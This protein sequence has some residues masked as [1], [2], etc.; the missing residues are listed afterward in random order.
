VNDFNYRI[1][2]ETHHRPWPL[3]NAPWCMTQT[4]HNLLFAHWPVDAGALRALV[5][6]VLQLD[7]YGGQAWIGV[8][9]FRMTNVAPRG[10]P[11]VPFVSA[12]PELNVRTYVTVGGKP[13]V[14]FF[15]LDAGSTVAVAAARML[16]GLPYFA[17][18]MRLDVSEGEVRYESEREPGSV[19]PAAFVGRYHP[20]GPVEPSLAG[21]LEHF[22]TER[23]CL[24]RVD[25]SLHTH[26][27][28]VHHEQWPLQVA[29]ATIERNT[30]AEAAGIRLPATAPLLHY[31][32]RMDMVAWAPYRVTQS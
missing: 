29:D 30:M 12:F 21:T 2:D 5:P 26:R 11:N 28:E 1:L 22:L 8:I 23:Y 27:L 20:T 10:I 15:S 19:G 32:H 3:P 9:P 7:V 16:L 6:Q 18:R 14:Y 24:Y 17:A 4:W 25:D 31:A 13:G